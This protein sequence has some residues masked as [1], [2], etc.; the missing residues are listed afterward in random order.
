MQNST[1]TPGTD[2][3]A[4]KGEYRVL[5]RRGQSQRL[6]T[7]TVVSGYSTK[8]S[9][10]QAKGVIR[11]VLSGFVGYSGYRMVFNGVSGTQGGYSVTF[12]ARYIRSNAQFYMVLYIYISENRVR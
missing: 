10:R 2:I 1:G 8:G 7:G 12:N 11:N 4:T 6:D 9:P 5:P 3:V